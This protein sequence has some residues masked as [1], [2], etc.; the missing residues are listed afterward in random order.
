MFYDSRTEEMFKSL[1][2]LPLLTD[3]YASTSLKSTLSLHTLQL[4]SV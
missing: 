3:I 2:P 4:L 1:I